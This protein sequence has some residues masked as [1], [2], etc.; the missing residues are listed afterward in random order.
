MQ[1]LSS[2]FAITLVGGVLLM[3]VSV[4]YQMLQRQKVIISQ[5][6]AEIDSLKYRA[7]TINANFGASLFSKNCQLCHPARLHTDNMFHGIVDRLGEPYLMLYLTK[8]DSLIAIEEKYAVQIKES[9]NSKANSHNFKFNR[10]ELDA[11]I[12]F[13]R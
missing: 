1:K 8:Q 11:I 3:G 5:K 6:Q 9:Y 4:A 2:L 12:A 13:L 7:N 10:P